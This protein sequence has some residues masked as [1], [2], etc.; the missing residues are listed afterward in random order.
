M[1][2]KTKVLARS[3]LFNGV[4]LADPAP[5]A[6]VADVQRM[7]SVGYPELTNATVDGPNM[8]SGVAVYT[9]TTKVGSK[10]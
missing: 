1:A 7:L 6:S 3:F 5:D 10:G 9:F 8:E 2:V 4:P